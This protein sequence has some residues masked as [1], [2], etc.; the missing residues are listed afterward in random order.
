MSTVA[1][2]APPIRALP[3]VLMDRYRIPSWVVDHESYRRWARSEQYPEHGWYSFLDGELWA[4]PSMEELFTHNLVKAEFTAVLV[5]LVKK[6]SLGYC[7]A[8]RVLWSHRL[9]GLTTEPDALFVSWEALRQERMQLM[10][11]T[12]RG[13]VELEGTPDMVLEIVSAS[14]VRKDTKVLRDLYWRAGVTE[15][16]LVDARGEVAQ[17][18]ILRRAARGY[19]T[20]RRQDGWLKSA[21]FARSFRLTQQTDPLGHPAYS[22]EVRE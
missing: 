15:Y 1:V 16:W 5:S 6:L 10:G 22:L 12:K 8:D 4:D 13:F 19:I 2:S 18:D 20:V 21:V 9:A 14:S 3:V 11:G 17:F 7:F